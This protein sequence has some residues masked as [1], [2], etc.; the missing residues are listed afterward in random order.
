M[1]V[2]RMVRGARPGL[3]MF[4][5]STGES[6]QVLGLQQQLDFKALNPLQSLEKRKKHVV[7]LPDSHS[8]HVFAHP[9]IIERRQ[10]FKY[11]TGE[12]YDEGRTLRRTWNFQVTAIN[13][14]Q[15]RKALLRSRPEDWSY[16]EVA[17]SVGDACRTS[18]PVDTI[19]ALK[20]VLGLEDH[21]ETS[22]LRQN[23][24]DLKDHSEIFADLERTRS[25]FDVSLLDDA[26]QVV[27]I[28]ID[29]WGAY[30]GQRQTDFCYCTA[31][32]R[33]CRSLQGVPAVKQDALG[34][35]G[36]ETALLS[37]VPELLQRI[38]FADDELK[39]FIDWK[40]KY[41]KRRNAFLRESRRRVWLY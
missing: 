4:T 34:I 19:D 41:T 10:Y 30:L 3:T 28:I 33:S 32:L 6:L 2:T 27:Q 39:Q 1:S 20:H 22:F 17:T 14:A 21:N 16:Q 36:G 38:E 24:K 15:A 25:I 8:L 26:E 12:P 40:K 5:R 7:K 23:F 31:V 35:I 9:N 13:P 11:P 29:A 37:R 18:R